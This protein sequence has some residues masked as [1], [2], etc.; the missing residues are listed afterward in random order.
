VLRENPGGEAPGGKAAG[1]HIEDGTLAKSVPVL[2]AASMPDLR[3]RFAGLSSR[4]NR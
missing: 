4:L 3:S 1:A 2:A